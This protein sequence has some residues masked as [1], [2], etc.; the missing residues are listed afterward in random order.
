MCS[1]E[2]STYRTIYTDIAELTY[3]YPIETVRG[4]NG[5]VRLSEEYICRNKILR[6]D[7]A[8]LVERIRLGLDNRDRSVFDSIFL[9][10]SLY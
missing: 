8:E 3:S 7:Q 5:G 9:Q 6:V 2:I 10:F 4:R 1:D